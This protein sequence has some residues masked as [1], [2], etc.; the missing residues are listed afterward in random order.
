MITLSLPSQD[1]NLYCTISDWIIGPFHPDLSGGFEEIP[2]P[3][4]FDSITQ[5]DSMYHENDVSHQK[6]TGSVQY[7]PIFRDVTPWPSSTLPD[8]V[9]WNTKY[10]SNNA[11]VYV[12]PAFGLASSK[13]VGRQYNTYPEFVQ[14]AVE[15]LTPYCWER[16]LVRRNSQTR[17]ISCERHTCAV[18]KASVTGITYTDA[19]WG[20][21]KVAATA[22]GD[23]SVPRSWLDVVS[24]VK[25]TCTQ[26]GPINT[27]TTTAYRGLSSGVFS[28]TTAKGVIDSF[29]AP[30]LEEKN[31]PLKDMHYGDLAQEAS[32]KV[33]ANNVNMIAFLKDLRH[34]SEL[35]PKLKNLRKLK[36]LAGN[37]LGLK[38]GVLPTVSDLQNIV[39]ALKRIKPYL[40]SNGY[41]TF[42]AVH[43]ESKSTSSN[44]YYLEQR[45]KIA[46]EKEDNDLVAFAT[47]VESAGFA[48]TLENTWDLI[49]Y[50]FVLDWFIGF[51][52]FLERVDTRMRL[53]RL[54]IRYATMSRK[55]RTTVFM[56]P[57][58]AL[59]LSGTFDVVHYQRWTSD[60]CPVPPL[61]LS[62]NLT[63]FNHWLEGTA[64]ILQRKK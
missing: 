25:K 49:P 15:Y 29:V 41:S 50:S 6:V 12:T 38:Y 28:P 58:L 9:N 16:F 57:T 34:P 27:R 51:G 44:S 17:V 36:T 46:I 5:G 1:T 59:P 53:S 35:L 26:M 54:N 55:Q 23:W 64:L 56:T 37:Y 10:A 20:E 4:N 2:L 45:I 33:N 52:D 39:D 43:S 22:E 21:W 60:Q 11:Q 7:L 31:F 61:S 42:N 62:S 48:P 13:K 63:S 8:R 24:L 18:T 19:Q 40:D 3:S 32:A 14:S 47:G 30:Y